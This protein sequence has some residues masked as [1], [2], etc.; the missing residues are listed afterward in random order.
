M[1]FQQT[2][3]YLY[4]RLPVFQNQG[5]KALNPGLEKTIAFCNH[6]GNP[7]NN[8]KSIHVGGTNGKGSSS[9]MLASVLQEAGYKVGLYTSPHLKDFRERFRVNGQMVTESF[10]TDFVQKHKAFI[11]FLKPSFF[12]VTVAMAFQIFANENVDIAVIEVGLGG[13]LDSTNV[14]TPVISLITNIGLDHTDILGDTHEKIAFEKAGIIKPQIPV[15]ISEYREDTSKIFKDKA[16]ETNSSIIF[17]ADNYKVKKQ[18]KYLVQNLSQ[19]REWELSLDLK[20]NYQAKNL[21]GVFQSIEV[22]QSIGYSKIDDAAILKGL[23][24]VVK[25]TGLKGRWQKLS[26]RPLIICDTGHNQEAFE[27]LRKRIKAYHKRKVH[28]ILA[29][30]RDKSVDILMSQMPSNV[31]Y[32][33]TKYQS[34]RSLEK[35]EMSEIAQKY[36]VEQYTWHDDVNQAIAYVKSIADQDAFIFVGG[37]TYLIAEINEL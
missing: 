7:Q 17:A 9:H 19:K 10:V 18:T 30:S 1:D 31:A 36:D 25:N 16:K 29:F 33:F 22:L 34:F 13:R 23:S 4:S 2:V 32:H 26:N 6:L 8:F 5:K 35:N 12:E 3:E 15:V 14:I 24:S 11:E 37:S 20:G 27:Y 21:V 28:L